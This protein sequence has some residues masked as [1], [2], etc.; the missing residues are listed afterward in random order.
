MGQIISI[1]SGKGGTG[2]TTTA[3]ALSSCLAVLGKRTLCIDFDAE[4][5][6]LD[7][8]LAMTDYAVMDFVDVVSGK[9]AFRESFSES[10]QIPNLF[11]LSAPAEQIP[12]NIGPEEI[13][14]MFKDIR[15]EFDY[16]II[17]VPAGVGRG[18]KLA[19]GSDMS[20]IVTTGDIPAMRNATRTAE[21][22]RGLGVK[23]L[24]LI[25]NKVKRKNFKRIKT[26]VDDIIDLTGVRLLAVVADDINV[27]LAL[28]AGTPLVLYKNRKAAYDFLDGARRLIGENIP[29]Y[30]R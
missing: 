20:I 24:R 28:H 6:N 30:K 5:R 27:H 17:D 25:V 10:P 19:S 12:S 22:L 2:K 9:V 26:T 4:L 3:A 18:F 11:F 29:L 1:T 21:A 23:K 7:L 8:A 15:A 16:C 13:S 14:M